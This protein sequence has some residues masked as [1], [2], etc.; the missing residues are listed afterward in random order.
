[1]LFVAVARDDFCQAL[2]VAAMLFDTLDVLLDAR[3]VNA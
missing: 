1:L 3:Q 2:A